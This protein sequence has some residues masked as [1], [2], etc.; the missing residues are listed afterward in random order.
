MVRLDKIYTRG[1]D[2]GMTSLGD[3]SR[4][5]KTSPRIASYGEVDELNA[6]LGLC[7]DHV[8][9][10]DER[11]M[12]VDIQ[13]ELFDLG[14]DLCIP[15]APGEE[16]RLRMSTAAVERLERIIDEVNEG[17]PALT[18]FVLPGGNPL[19]S[20]YHLA[21]T[22][23]RRVERALVLLVQGAGEGAVNK[24]AHAYVNRLSDLLFV[25]ARRAAGADEV[26]WE[27]GRGADP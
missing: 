5:S 15:V 13:H 27:P 6:V 23:C 17:L 19:A 4:V 9:D 21:R 16:R 3:G 2:D 20:H 25:L 18:S 7:L 26:L 1:G 12:L 11:R 8:R 24:A 22:V 10:D 14:A